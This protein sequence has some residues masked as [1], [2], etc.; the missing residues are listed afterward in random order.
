MVVN[1]SLPEQQWMVELPAL[2]DC[3]RR[4]CLVGRALIDRCEV[5]VAVDDL[6]RPVLAAVDVVTR[7]VIGAIGLPS[8]DALKRSSRTV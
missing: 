6:P 4:R 5:A 8:T 2:S 7:I 3:L 1:P